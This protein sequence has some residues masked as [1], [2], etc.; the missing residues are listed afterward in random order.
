[1]RLFQSL[2]E[3]RFDGPTVLAIGTFDGLH[4]GHQALVREL[5]ASARKLQARS[6]VI[7]FHPRPKTVLAP[8][9]PNNDY[10]TTAAERIALF[11]ELEL[12]VLVL[13][14]FT[15]E[16]AQTS[17]HDF[18]RP[19]VEN[20]NVVQFC[21]GHDFA[22]GKNREGNVAKLTELGHEFNYSLREI[23]PF[24]L[25][26]KIVSSTKVRQHLLAGD[27]RPASQLLGRYPS[28][29]GHIVRGAQ[30]GRTI[31]FPTANFFVPPERLVPANGVYATFIRRSGHGTRLSSVTNIGL[32]P[33]FG[34]DALTVE[35]YIFDFDEDIY[36]QTFSLEFVE[37]LRPEKKFD[38]VDSLVT[39]ITR[40]A[41]RARIVLAA[42]V[43]P[44]DQKISPRLIDNKLEN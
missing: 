32:R 31:G 33:S 35:T 40:D 2:A 41:E 44:A 38:G 30:R 25:N 9:L 17:A 12:D 13:T 36:G 23:E 10:L 43:V 22:L 37:R 39:Q 16:L 42:E 27:V 18:V 4:R 26:G 24:L 6:A 11:E 28:L 15:L 34:D 14:P 20:L 29:S 3:A 8:H 5:I 7:A 19:V 1:M 21:V